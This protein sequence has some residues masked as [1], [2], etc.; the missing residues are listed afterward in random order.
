MPDPIIPK[1]LLSATLTFRRTSKDIAQDIL[2]AGLARCLNLFPPRGG[3][4]L[5]QMRRFEVANPEAALER[6]HRVSA[7]ELIRILTGRYPQLDKSCLDGQHI[8]GPV[9]YLSYHL[10]NWEWLGGIFHKLHGDFRPLTRSIR[11]PI[12]HRKIQ[13]LRQSVGMNSMIDHAGLRGGRTALK[14]GAFLAFLADQTPPGAS[15]PG[16]CLGCDLPVSPLPEWWSKGQNFRWLTGNLLATSP[17][18]YDLD[19]REFPSIAITQ[20]DRLLDEHLEPILRHQPEH[21]FGWWHHR[22]LSRD[23]SRETS[24]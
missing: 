3:L 7:R 16:R 14:E 12:I 6:L 5:E 11:S 19:V 9:L 22:L 21:Y 8:E 2:S 20:W 4:A 15:R 1:L 17:T 10:G 13:R 24:R 23:V 18:Q